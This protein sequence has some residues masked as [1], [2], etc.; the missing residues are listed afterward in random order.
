MNVRSY[1]NFKLSTRNGALSN[2]YMRR[3]DLN[4]WKTEK[5]CEC[6]NMGK[7]GT[8]RIMTAAVRYFASGSWT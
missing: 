4:E 7:L 1:F 6:T 2:V 5:R 3:N 8:T